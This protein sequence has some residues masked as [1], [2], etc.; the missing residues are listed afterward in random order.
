MHFFGRQLKPRGTVVSFLIS[1]AHYSIRQPRRVLLIAALITLA[2]SLGV[3]RLKMRTDGHT[4]VPENA[5]EVIYDRAVRA[6]FGIQD[7]IIVLV[8]SAHP[9]GIFNPV[10]VQ[11]IRELTGE[12]NQM[13]GMASVNVISLASEPSF[14]FRPG[15][16]LNQ[17][18]LEP[19]LTNNVELDRLRDDLGQILLY[20]GTLVSR[21]G[22][23][24]VI[25]IGIPK[26]ADRAQAY[27]AV[28]R[29]VDARHDVQDEISVTGAPVAESLLGTQILEDLGVPGSLLG[30]NLQK[31]P[32]W[33][34]PSNWHELRLLATRRLGL[35]PLAAL[36]MMGVFLLC[37]RNVTAALLPLPGIVATMLFVFGLMGWCKVPLYLTTAVMPVLLTVISVTNDIYLLSRY[38]SLLRQRTGIDHVDLVRETF[39]R[40]VSPVACT[41]LTAIVGFLSFG[42]SPLVPVRA[43]GICTGAGA[44]FGLT[45]SLSVVPALLALV[46]PTWL[47]PRRSQNIAWSTR[48]GNWFARAGE[49][50]QRRRRWV[51]VGAMAVVAF[52]PLGLRNLVVQDSWISGFDPSSKFRRATGLVNE[53]FFGMHLLFVSFDFSRSLSG[54]IGTSNTANGFIILPTSLVGDPALIEGSPIKFSVHTS[55]GNLISNGTQRIWLSHVKRAILR[56]DEVFVG[57]D[58]SELPTNFWEELY[59]NGPLQFEVL[60]QSQLRPEIIQEIANMASFLREKRSYAV[61]G[62]LSPADYLATTRFMIRYSD[63]QARRLPESAAEAKFIWKDYRTVLGPVRLG[64]IVDTNY[65]QSLTTV[66]LKDANFVDTAKLMGDLRDYEREHLAPKGIKIGFA[67]DVAVSQALIHGIVVTQMQSLI[68]SLVGIFLVTSFFGGSWRWGSYCLLPSLLAVVVKF[69]VMG[70]AGI[71]LGVATSMFAAMTLGIGVNCAIHLLE[72][73]RMARA[74]GISESETLKVSLG[75]TG[76][77]ALI[78]TLAMSLGFG[79]LMLSQVPANARLGILLILGLVNCFVAS[80]LLLPA[81]LDCWPIKKS[82]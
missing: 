18:L 22:K 49:I 53:N 54:S 35:V 80:L 81:L 39:D 79:V 4:L 25:L 65:G 9:D 11:L 58:H 73:C 14:R 48:L 37:F 77:P 34:R 68:W 3:C 70:W 72:G 76:P 38:L 43:F 36:V 41:S 33:S 19:A 29:V 17:R 66:F 64:Q 16:Y 55:P 20:N 31:R 71:P 2:A 6:H 56:G 24:S 45:F 60:E 12:F 30:A 57:L 46:N 15:T 63:P 10:T 44:L 59:Q 27:L 69:A 21:D 26:N 82:L 40:L 75:Q 67:G 74:R 28:R 61:G 78:N 32:G 1:L 52:T 7:N 47:C 8:R 5:P 50:L 62:V 23:S 42:L 51:L 13:P